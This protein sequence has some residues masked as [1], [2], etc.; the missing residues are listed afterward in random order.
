[1][2]TTNGRRALTPAEVAETLQITEKLLTYHRWNRTG[3]PYFRVGRWV[4][5][6]SED[7]A[8]WIEEQKREAVPGAR[9]R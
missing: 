7:L 5:Y 1:M 2:G 3:P 4:R 6:D 9:T 8:K